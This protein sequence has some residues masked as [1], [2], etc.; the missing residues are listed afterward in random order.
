MGN[1]RAPPPGTKVKLPSAKY[2]GFC[3]VLFACDFACVNIEPILCS[4]IGKSNIQG[5]VKFNIGSGSESC[6]ELGSVS[7]AVVERK[8]EPAPRSRPELDRE[9]ELDRDH[10][11]RRYWSM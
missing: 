8:V 3:K 11:R 7:G 10:G 2:L 5:K 1:K 4:G 6:T 9:H